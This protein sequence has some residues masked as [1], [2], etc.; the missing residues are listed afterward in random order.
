MS[1]PNL[2]LSIYP[3]SGVADY[4]TLGLCSANYLVLL[5]LTVIAIHN[6]D[7][8]PIKAK[9][10]WVLCLLYL[11]SLIWWFSTSVCFLFSKKKSQQIQRCPFTLCI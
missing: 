9:Q 7:F 5:V 6:R 8:L 2:T 1:R 3:D 10:L 11:S 4:I